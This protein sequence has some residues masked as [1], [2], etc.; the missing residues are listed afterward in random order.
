MLDSTYCIDIALQTLHM[1]IPIMWIR[2]L[3]MERV[4]IAFKYPRLSQNRF[5]WVPQNKTSYIMDPKIPSQTTSK[6]KN[7]KKLTQMIN[8][9]KSDN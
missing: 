3:A 8:F 2:Y 4:Q 7:V 1:D 9:D 5:F 6:Y